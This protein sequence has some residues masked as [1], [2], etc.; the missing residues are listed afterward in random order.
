MCWKSSSGEYYF[1]KVSATYWIEKFNGENTH[2][3]KF[4]S[5]SLKD[6]QV[7][8]QSIVKYSQEI[9]LKFNSSGYYS[10]QN[11]ENINVLIS[12]GTWAVDDFSL[13]NGK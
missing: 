10:G 13:K 6:M 4:I 1:Y 7:I 12:D 5:Q 9:Y 3:Y 2:A 8:L 11:I